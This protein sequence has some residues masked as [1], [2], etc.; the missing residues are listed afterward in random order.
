MDTK[1]LSRAVLMILLAAG[2]ASAQFAGTGTTTLQVTPRREA[3]IQIN[4]ASTALST[5]GTVFNNFTG[6]TNITYK[7]RTTQ[8]TGAG[9]ITLQVTSDFSPVGGPSVATPPTAGDTLK[10]TCTVAAPGT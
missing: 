8:S 4:T 5:S 2:L 10:Y 6:T 7:I 3:A 9:S 1:R